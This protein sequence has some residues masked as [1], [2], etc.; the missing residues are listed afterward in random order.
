MPRI[1]QL[2]P[3]VVTKI[4]AG[5]V[6]E[7]PASVVKELLENSID[8]GSTRI[9]VDLDAGGTELI[10]VA[11]D[12]CGIAPDDLPL[13]FA[14]HATS[15]LTTAD[16]LFAIGTMGFRGEAL[17]S[18]AGIAKVTLQSRPHDKS[19][20]AEVRCDGGDLSPVRPWNGSPGT[21]IEVRH[22]FHNVP[23]RKK[24]LKSIATEL[25]HVCETV[26]RL[27]LANPSLH[28]TLR[29]NGKL[30]YDI[31]GTAGLVDR[32]GLFFGAEVRDSLYEIDSGPGATRATGFIADPKCDRGNAKL[33]YLFING[34]WFR[35]RSVAHAMQEA[36]RGLLMS[37]RYAVGF[38]FLT[39]PPDK[40]DVNVHPTK[41]EVRFQE[42][43]LI[44]SM[45][46]SAVKARLLKENLVPHLTAPQGEPVG[47]EEPESVIRS[48]DPLEPGLFAQPTREIDLGPQHPVIGVASPR[49]ELA[50]RTVAP[51]ETDRGTALASPPSWR[52]GDASPPVETP[53][54]NTG[55]LASPARLD[56]TP[57][58]LASHARPEVEPAPAPIVVAPPEVPPP[59]PELPAAAPPAGTAMQIQDTYLVLET[60]EGMLVID[61]HALHERILFEQ[62]RRRIRAGQLEVQRLLIPEPIDLPAEQA[63]LV[64]EAA[65]ELRELGLEVSDFGGNTVLLSSYPTLL[66]RKPAHVIFQGVVDHLVTK[67]RPPTRDAM[68]HLLMATMA[69]KAAVK[70]GD[71]LTPEEVAHLLH[72]R[73]LAEDSHHCPHGR[74]TSLLF[75]RQELDKQ[76]RRV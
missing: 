22:L 50:S 6:I 11:D 4:A 75:S 3:D 51:W 63:A 68:L 8:A 23:V 15:K 41:A 10:R 67:E 45:V 5:E 27:A 21:R 65:D 12:G 14:V 53:S 40:V 56:Q 61:Q 39:V 9:D 31:P 52:A 43:S 7:R 71:R 25:G 17:A 70:A 60:P 72:L 32:I 20:G 19:V 35:D 46:R 55:G 2:P 74:P 34:R 29:H 13:A 33:Q 76:F 42:N 57:G 62:L 37:G 54:R 73:Q 26:T 30:V 69:C 16:D 38:V 66:G 36:Y 24:F 64:L 59:A 18:V 47:F 44:Y 48:R 1:H 49:Q 58:G 28:I